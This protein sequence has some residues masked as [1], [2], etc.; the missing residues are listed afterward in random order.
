MEKTKAVIDTCF[1]K[2]I[3]SDGKHV[4]NLKKVLEELD[5]KP[6]VHPY[7]AEH[8][9]KLV[10]A[11][12]SLIEEGYIEVI[13][14]SEFIPTPTHEKLYKKQFEEL[15]KEL[16]KYIDSKKHSKKS[17][18]NFDFAKDDI[19]SSHKVGSSL[20]D[21]HTVLM[22]Y[23]LGLPVVLTEDSDISYLKTVSDQKFK[24]K[25]YKITIYNA[26]DLIIKIASNPECGIQ[27]NELEA[28]LDQMGG[29]KH[30]HDVRA[31]WREHHEST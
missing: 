7:C 31:I 22:A 23:Y 30:R 5:Y 19:F 4:D 18:P 3:S 14:Y 17:M 6:V 13:P 21:V 15:F 20:A 27:K 10:D 12:K 8:E 2:K 16:K 11:Y 24:L 28:I 29:R 26:L 9:L 25:A 1:L